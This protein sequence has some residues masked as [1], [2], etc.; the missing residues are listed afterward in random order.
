MLQL[1]FISEVPPLCLPQTSF[2]EMQISL[3]PHSW[4]LFAQ[5]GTILGLFFN[6]QAESVLFQISLAQNTAYRRVQHRR[7]GYLSQSQLL[8]Q[9]PEQFLISLQQ[10]ESAENARYL[11]DSWDS[12]CVALVLSNFS[13]G[14]IS[15]RQW[16]SDMARFTAV[17]ASSLVERSCLFPP[18]LMKCFPEALCSVYKEANRVWICKS[19]CLRLSTADQLFHNQYGLQSGPDTMRFL[20]II[21]RL[22]PFVVVEILSVIRF[23]SKFFHKNPAVIRKFRTGS[24]P[25]SIRP[26]AAV[27]SFRMQYM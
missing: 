15:T 4:Q 14:T 20:Q 19:S 18:A 26:A 17:Q 10:V 1:R 8:Q 21:N 16:S 11:N 12:L 25:G 6:S 3:L 2:V 5:E 7:I 13:N 27:L 24:D 22:Y 23:F 9:H